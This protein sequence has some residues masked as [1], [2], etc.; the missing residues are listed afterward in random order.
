MGAAL[1]ALTARLSAEESQTA[2]AIVARH[3]REAAIVITA[4]TVGVDGL[5]RD[6][7]VLLLQHA[8]AGGNA[9]AQLLLAAD[10]LRASPPAAQAAAARQLAVHKAQQLGWDT[11]EMYERLSAYRH[12]TAWRGD[13]LPLLSERPAS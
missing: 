1:V 12:D 7:E 10:L 6:P 5:A 3:G 8:A 2:A 13:L 4:L 9:S 11:R